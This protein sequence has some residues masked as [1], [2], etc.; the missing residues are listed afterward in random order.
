MTKLRAVGLRI[1]APLLIVATVTAACSSTGSGD[2]EKADKPLVATTF[3]VLADMAQRIGGDRVTVESITRP[4]AD[5]HEYEPTSG[6]L[7]RVAG[8]D[9]LISNGLGVD[10][11]LSRFLDS[12]DAAH[13]VAS[14]G[15]E[16]MPIRSGD[17]EGK[18]NPHAWMSPIAGRTYLHNI[19]AA[20]SRVD[21]EGEREYTERAEEFGAELDAL[22]TRATGV[23]EALPPAHRTLVTCEGAF[24]YLARDVGLDELYLWAV[25]TEAQGTPQQV[26]SLIDEVRERRVPAVFCESTVSD[27]AM[28][29]VARA[30]G[31]R[32]AGTLYVDSLS[33]PE[34]DVP[35][36][37]DLVGHDLDLITEG[38]SSR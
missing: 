37:V 7:K 27:S 34:G 14:E 15:V 33:G 36:Y 9:L 32:L 19:A 16:P 1:L 29:Q 21:P 12:S 35:T 20:L 31:A 3:T 13:A 5:I 10:D 38:L 25:N 8:A 22:H 30:T 18:P 24:S 6:D 23:V 11:W 26:A 4:G 17:Y 2:G 28:Q